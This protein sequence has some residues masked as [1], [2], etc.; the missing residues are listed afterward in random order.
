MAVLLTSRS[1]TVF[2]ET[3]Q[4]WWSYRT[5][6]TVAAFVTALLILQLYRWF[7]LAVG[8]VV[9]REPWVTVAGVRRFPAG[10]R[11]RSGARRER[12]V[13][14]RRNGHPTRTM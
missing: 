1:A 5:S 3:W 8:R 13:P 10:A 2:A 7:H 9:D 6:F 12:S 14:I 11:R 4:T